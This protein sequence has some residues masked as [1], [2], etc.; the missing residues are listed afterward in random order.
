MIS[1]PN[2]FIKILLDDKKRRIWDFNLKS[3]KLNK[4][5]NEL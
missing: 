4:I 2:E 5:S 3:A 1:T